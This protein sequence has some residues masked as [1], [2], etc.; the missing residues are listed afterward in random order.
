MVWQQYILNNNGTINHSQK[1]F[2]PDIKLLNTYAK[3]VIKAILYTHILRV[4]KSS[5]D[6]GHTGSTESVVDKVYN[7]NIEQIKI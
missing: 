5:F 4:L 2:L 1:V 3:K 6:T 7:L